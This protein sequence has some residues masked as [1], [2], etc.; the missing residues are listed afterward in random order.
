MTDAFAADPAH[1]PFALGEGRAR[2]LLIPGFMGT[3]KEMRPLGE[4]LAAAGLAVRG[5]LLPGFGPDSARLGAV[6]AA[7]WLRAANDAWDEVAEGAA[8]TTLVGF[9]MGGAVALQ[10]AARRAPDRLVLIA[11]H[12][13]F[14]DR[15]ALALPVAK[16]VIRAIRPF[17]D[18]D[19]ANPGVRQAFAE[20]APG[21]DLDDPAVQARLRRE[22]ALPTATLDELRRVSAGGGA[23]AHRVDAPTLILQGRSDVTVLPR[24]TR[25]L[26]TCVG[27]PISLHELSGGHLL[28]SPEGRSWPAVRDLVVRFATSPEPA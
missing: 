3:P 10:L 12:W 25:R 7:D 18:A 26:A 1:Q 14:A 28:V 22:T 6:R 21:A 23:V 20:M 4:A 8:R 27:G 16:H 24:D 15:R 5:I 17:Q 2:A 9:S 19:F 13:R 11:P